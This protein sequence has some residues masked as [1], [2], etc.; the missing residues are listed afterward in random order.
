MKQMRPLKLFVSLFLIG[1][2]AQAGQP[3]APPPYLTRVELKGNKVIVTGINFDTDDGMEPILT[4]LSFIFLFGVIRVNPS[5][6]SSPERQ[7]KPGRSSKLKGAYHV[8]CPYNM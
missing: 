2:I 8:N 7:D 1:T 6:P 3:Q 5:Y 4:D